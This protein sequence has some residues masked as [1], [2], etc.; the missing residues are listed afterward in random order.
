MLRN[1][2]RERL[3]RGELALGIGLRLARSADIAAAMRAAG[4]DWLFIDLEHG[5]MSLETAAQI[6]IAAL[7]A[8]ITP[9]VRVAADALSEGT[10]L[11]DNGALGI[12]V[13]HVDS[14]E[15]AQAV[16]ARFRYPPRGGRSVTLSLPFFDHGPVA[17]AHV[18]QVL[19]PMTL[20]VAMIETPQAVASVAEIAAV[21]G[22]DILLVG[23]RDLSMTMEVDAKDPT[24]RDACARVAKACRTH[25][26][27]AGVTGIDDPVLMGDCQSWGMRFILT[28]MD[29]PL[30]VEAAAKRCALA[31]NA[32]A[33]L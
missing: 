28:G 6:C 18:V 22:I 25:R 15:Q 17:A 3:E 16:A 31:R 8:Q 11:L 30:L 9:I 7:G 4:F 21:P 13:P 14:V 26:K 5:A 12:V 23:A 2:A 20:V 10:R 27:W 33:A 24:V 19:D 32:G 29:L 1:P